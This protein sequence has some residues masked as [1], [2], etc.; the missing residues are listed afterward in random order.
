VQESAVWPEV[1][2][3]DDHRLWRPE[4]TQDRS[5]LYWYLTFVD[6]PSVAALADRARGRL[7]NLAAIDPVPP[8]WLHLTLCDIGFL[9]E[10]DPGRLEDMTRT[11]A[12]ELRLQPPLDLTLGPVGCFPDSVTLAAGPWSTLLELRQRIGRA[13]E[14]VGLVPQHHHAAQFVPHVTLGYLNRRADKDSVME[15]LGEGD[16]RGSVRVDHVTLAAV[17]RRD[18]HYQWDAG[19]ILTLGGARLRQAEGTAEPSRTGNE[20]TP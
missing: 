18:G 4:W 12:D 10:L 6:Q 20:S 16:A 5:C 17:S 11:V 15:A 19:A 9:D 3:L 14:S 2:V 8:R 13:M 1:E 7:G